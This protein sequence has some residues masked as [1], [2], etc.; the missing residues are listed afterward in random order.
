VGTK[1][2]THDEHLRTNYS[3]VHP[4]SQV[5]PQALAERDIQ[6][7]LLTEEKLK[8]EKK[9]NIGPKEEKQEEIEARRKINQQGKQ[10][11]LVRQNQTV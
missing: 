10:L 8:E 1:L 4:L 2:S 11:T 5:P 6:Y 3:M 9:A 7:W